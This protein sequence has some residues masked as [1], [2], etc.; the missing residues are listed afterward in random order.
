MTGDPYK[1][2]GNVLNTGLIDNLPADACVEVPCLVDG[3]GVHP[4]HV[5]RL[6][7]QLAAMN[8][9]NIN[10]QLLTIEAAVTK[11]R[12]LIYNAAMLEPHTAAELDIDHIAA[13]VDELI[14]AHG[15]YLPKYH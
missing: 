9:T 10:A 14:E 11:K 3:D 12:D 5:G 13:M 1:I 15:D 2:G 4:C 8:M 6:P 7:V